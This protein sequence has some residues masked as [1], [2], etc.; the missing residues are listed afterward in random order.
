MN[1]WSI[2]GDSNYSVSQGIKRIYIIVEDHE[3]YRS[4][5]RGWV[6]ASFANFHIQETTNAEEAIFLANNQEPD[7]LLIDM[8]RDLSNC[9]EAIRSIKRVLPIAQMVVLSFQE[10]P[11][12]QK[13]VFAAGAN[14]FLIKNQFRA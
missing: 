11:E 13:K 6:H 8:G 14:G 4:S 9:L 2:M 10:R 3:V 7:I 1:A 12:I 5:L